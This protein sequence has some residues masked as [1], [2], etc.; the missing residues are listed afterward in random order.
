MIPNWTFEVLN[1]F[2]SSL[3]VLVSGLWALR[4]LKNNKYE[5]SKPF[6]VVFLFQISSMVIAG[7]SH[8]L[9]SP[10]LL[11]FSLILMIP[12]TFLII[13]YLDHRNRFT[14]DPTKMFIFGI[15]VWEFF[16][17]LFDSSC[18]VIVELP[19]GGSS[20]RYFGN[21]QI[22]VTILGSLP[23]LLFS[24]YCVM[25]FLK[26][27]TG[28]KRKAM[29]TLIGGLIFGLATIGFVVIQSYVRIP[30]IAFITLAIGT[31]IF[32]LSLATNP[33][34]L[35][36]IIKSFSNSRRFQFTKILP[37]CANC[38]KIRDE[39]G[40]WHVIE[41]YL[42]ECSDTRC[43]HGLCLPCA[44]ELYNYRAD[45]PIEEDITEPDVII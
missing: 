6:V 37:I 29:L 43:S 34:I 31:F 30:G 1:I 41:E 12:I 5:I 13:R 16:S 3:L 32:S 39:E 18:L 20:I 35:T 26:S 4:I 33:K 9:L 21:L 15:V 11:Q 42:L 22:W 45:N 40:N 8:L 19:S 38:K 23:L 10:F 36:L 2:L 27:P 14:V 17:F 7:I 44:Q 25:L 24:Y 28:S